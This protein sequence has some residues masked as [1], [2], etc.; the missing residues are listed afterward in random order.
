M[1]PEGDAAALPDLDRRV[2]LR[3]SLGIHVIHRIEGVAVDGE[4]R[5]LHPV[6]GQ[7]IRAEERAGFEREFRKK[8][9]QDASERR[10]L[11]ARSHRHR[12]GLVADRIDRARELIH[13]MAERDVQQIDRRRRLRLRL[14]GKIMPEIV[15]RQFSGRV[16]QQQDQIG[17]RA[18]A[19]P[20]KIALILSPLEV[21]HEIVHE[22]PQISVGNGLQDG[23]VP[24]RMFDHDPIEAALER[25][26]KEGVGI[27]AASG[28]IAEE[29]AS[30]RVQDHRKRQRRAGNGDHRIGD[31][32]EARL[33]LVGK[34]DHRG[35]VGFEDGDILQNVPRDRLRT[36]RRTDDD[37]RFGGKIDMFLVLHHIGGDRHVAKLAQLDPD[38][39]GR[40]LVRSASDDRPVPFLLHHLFHGA[41]DLLLPR[42]D[43]LHQLRRLFE[44][45]ELLGDPFAGHGREELGQSKGQHVTGHDLRIE[46]LGRGDGHFDV[47]AVGG[48]KNTVGLCRDIRLAAVYNRDD[49]RT[50]LHG[51]GHGTIGIRRCSRLGNR[52]D[53]GLPKAVLQAEAA[54]FGGDP[55][56]HADAASVEA[57]RHCV[58]D[59]APGDGRRPMTDHDDPPDRPPA[60]RLPNALREDVRTEIEGGALPAPFPFDPVFAE[61]GLPDGV[62]RFGNLLHEVVGVVAAIDVPGRDLRP[63]HRLA[64]EGQ[65][66]PVVEEPPNAGRPSRGILIQ[67]ED[68]S[69]AFRHVRMG[70]PLAL[71]LD[72]EGG[73]LHQT[74]E[75]RGEEIPVGGDSNVDRLAAS[76]QGQKNLSGLGAADH[77]NGMGAL[78][79]VHGKPER[80]G[81]AMPRPQV[82]LDLQRNDLRVGRHFR[83]DPPAR[84]VQSLPERLVVVDI[85]V[86]DHV[87]GPATLP[88]GEAQ[89]GRF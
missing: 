30:H 36:P 48:V 84:L 47:P 86:Q 26:E 74:V 87:D 69:G 15:E 46:G 34:N 73:L 81:H 89:R 61:Q 16:F 2:V 21:R 28:V 37:Q 39:I 35:L 31:R 38:L 80:I 55:C 42:E 27:D 62:G 32:I 9:E 50:P 10:L 88:A 58:G 82:F 19:G 25:T 5:L 83:R 85:A 1:H 53:Q 24:F 7:N 59:G 54:Q 23:E 22:T 60:E 45:T 68:L 6:E 43:P 3:F 70:G 17:D 72:E 18:H 65:R 56:L 77:C 66:R 29:V 51:H 11:P 79:I 13:R 67:D 78:K 8:I 4:N 57:A 76:L 20:G 71:H 75:L 40:R 64:S 12:L 14:R 41:A 52:D 33:S 49:L 44:Q 63:P